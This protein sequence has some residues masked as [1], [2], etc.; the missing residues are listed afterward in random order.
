[1][2]AL[3]Q[4]EEVCGSGLQ[5]SLGARRGFIDGCVIRQVLD[6]ISGQVAAQPNQ[7][8]P[9]AATPVGQHPNQPND[10]GVTKLPELVPTTQPETDKAAG[11]DDI[12]AGGGHAG[13]TTLPPIVNAP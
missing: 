10:P 7:P 2:A 9:N 4:Q 6:T 13:G 3:Q 11:P 5:S 12:P 1:M 8:R